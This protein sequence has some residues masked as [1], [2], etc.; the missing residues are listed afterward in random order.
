[1]SRPKILEGLT[2]TPSAP[3]YH[4]YRWCD[5]VELRCLTHKDKRF[6]RDNLQES[7]LESKGI[8][9][10]SPSIEEIDDEEFEYQN[11]RLQWGMVPD[12]L[13]IGNYKDELKAAKGKM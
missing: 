8:T 11:K 4:L 10:T 6:S 1:M 7:M 13:D 12:P 9:I 5:Y 2:A 3:K